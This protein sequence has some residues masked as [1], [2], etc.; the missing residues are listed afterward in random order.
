MVMFVRL[1]MSR[2][3]LMSNTIEF[4]DSK[5]RML[6]YM[7]LVCAAVA[8]KNETNQRWSEKVQKCL[9]RGRG[10]PEENVNGWKVLHHSLP[11]AKAIKVNECV[12]V[13]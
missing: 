8:E 1:L 12:C 10:T 5:F 2:L 11:V 13:A 4:N 9:A 7:L 6:L 3:L